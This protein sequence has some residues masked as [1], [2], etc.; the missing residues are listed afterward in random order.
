MVQTDVV[1]GE[2]SAA[3]AE[4]A[5][6]PGAA[7]IVMATHGRTGA[8]RAVMG[9]V[10]GRVLEQGN[11]PLVLVRPESGGSPAGS[12]RLGGQPVAGARPLSRR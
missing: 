6:D 2:P 11:V 3:I 10:A 8:P 7:L 4:A 9:S 5:T 1:F 12:R